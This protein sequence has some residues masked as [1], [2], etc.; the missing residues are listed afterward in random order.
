MKNWKSL[1]GTAL[2]LVATQWVPAALGQSPQPPPSSVQSSPRSGTDANKK[3]TSSEFGVPSKK[4]KKFS[5]LTRNPEPGTRNI[6]PACMAT[7]VELEQTRVL[8]LALESENHALAERL[9]TEKRT[10]VVLTELNETRKSEAEALRSVV[11]AKNETISAKTAVIGA[12]DK[13]IETLKKKK[14]SPWRR[15]G[16]ILIGAAVFAIFK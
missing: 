11:T 3:V 8:V 6:I 9:D 7:A 5:D 16:D 14:T 10:T 2:A 15:V 1:I 4:I 12:Q 13:L